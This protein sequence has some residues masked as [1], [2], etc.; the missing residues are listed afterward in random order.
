MNT[1]SEH[2]AQPIIKTKIGNI[3]QLVHVLGLMQNSIDTTPAFDDDKFDD[4]LGCVIARIRAVAV[5]ISREHAKLGGTKA[6][7]EFPRSEADSGVNSIYNALVQ[8]EDYS[9]LVAEYWRTIDHC[10]TQIPKLRKEVRQ[11]KAIPLDGGAAPRLIESVEMVSRVEQLVRPGQVDA[12]R[13]ALTLKTESL[14]AAIVK[15]AAAEP[16]VYE[17]ASVIKSLFEKVA[18]YGNIPSKTAALSAIDNLE[19]ADAAVVAAAV[20]VKSCT[21]VKEHVDSLDMIFDLEPDVL[22][23]NS[24]NRSGDAE[25]VLDPDGVSAATAV[26]TSMELVFKRADETPANGSLITERNAFKLS[27]MYLYATYVSNSV[28][29]G[30]CIDSL[31]R[32][33]PLC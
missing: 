5:L 26:L 28:H 18:S 30:V 17:S 25:L 33:E 6:D 14:A 29:G 8:D 32:L 24:K 15:F 27:A 3:S 22:T 1:F 16:W 13:E 12:L 7:A 19:N 11:L 4:A 20:F 9:A 10:T 31:K 21:A 23:M 2:V